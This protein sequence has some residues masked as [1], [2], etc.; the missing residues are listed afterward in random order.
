MSVVKQKEQT[1]SS[2][3][4]RQPT[5][6]KNENITAYDNTGNSYTFEV[7]PIGIIFR[8]VAGVYIFTK[9]SINQQGNSEYTHLYI[10]ETSSFKT[11]PLIR[12]RKVG[13]SSQNGIQSYLRT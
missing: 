11:D 7:Y 10:G 3:E 1:P 6:L 12:A 13:G 2:I 5:P 4:S 9:K 8:A